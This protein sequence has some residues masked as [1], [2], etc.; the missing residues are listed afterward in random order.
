LVVSDS[1]PKPGSQPPPAETAKEAAVSSADAPEKIANTPEKAEDSATNALDDAAKAMASV[2]L[3]SDVPAAAADAI[4]KD[5]ASAT[6]VAP[7]ASKPEAPKPAVEIFQLPATTSGMHQQYVAPGVARQSFMSS[8][9]VMVI[10]LGIMMTFSIYVLFGSSHDSLDL[11]GGQGNGDTAQPATTATTPL[12]DETATHFPNPNTVTPPPTTPTADFTVNAATIGGAN[13]PLTSD[14]GKRKGDAGVNKGGYA[15]ETA[16]L[17]A[18]EAMVDKDP[19]KALQLVDQHDIDYPRGILDPRARVIRVKAYAKKGDDVK[20]L[21]LGNDF[22]D[23]Y[24][25]SPGAGGVGAIVEALKNKLDS[26]APH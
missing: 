23:D 12:V 25:H 19:T 24:P 26:G 8:N 2:A 5:S 1:P 6:S 20:A 17:D 21:E 14:G 11:A 7:D 16:D 10:C 3:K 22:L 4:V 18:A 9:R 13:P 15:E